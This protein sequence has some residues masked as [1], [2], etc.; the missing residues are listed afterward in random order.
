MKRLRAVLCALIFS[1]IPAYSYAASLGDM[2]IDYLDGD[3]Q[4]KTADTSEWVPASINMPLMDGDAVWV[5]EGGRAGIQLRDGTSVRLAESSSLEILAIGGDSFQFYLSV[6]HAFVNFRGQ[7]GALFQTDTPVS[8]SRA[9]NRARFRIDVSDNGFTDVSVFT[10]VVFTEGRNG[11]TKVTAGNILSIGGDTYAELAPLGPADDWERWNDDMDKK[12]EQRYSTRYL[13]S[14]LSAYSYDFDEY[15]KWVNSADYGYVWIPTAVSAGWSPYRFGR[16]TWIGGDYVWVS[17]DP[18]GWAPYHYGRWA[19]GASTGW[20]WVP[21]ARGAAY[22][23]PGYVAWVNTPTYVS[24][25]PLAPGEIYYG[26]GYYGPHSVNITNININT[27]HVTNVYRNSHVN[28]A[29]T[30]V[31]RD[32]FVS[33]RHVDV[34]VR[35]NP[36]LSQRVSVGRPDIAPTR[37]SYMPVVKSISASKEPPRA[38]R[39]IEVNELRQSRPVVKNPN[40]SVLRPGAPARQM[41]VTTVNRPRL[42][43]AAVQPQGLQPR[44]TGRE[45]QRGGTPPADKGTRGTEVQ[46]GGTPPADKGTR[47]TEVQRGGTPPA[48]KGTRG[49]EVQRGGTPPADKGTRGTEVQR[50]GTPPAD[51]GTRGT[52]VQRGGTPPADKGTRGTEVQR[53]G[54]PPADKGT[55]GTEVQRGGTPPAD[56]GTAGRQGASQQKT[57]DKEKEQPQETGPARVR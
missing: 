53:G 32:T 49:T 47:G 12:L 26:H 31:H 17:Y 35:E 46:R 29:V 44:T 25:V 28:N 27:I 43:G 5:P 14:E 24:W 57:Q 20:C 30:V 45:V 22:W 56:K 52:E 15:G 19:F 13:P 55:R 40:E 21:P 34:N 18:W 9:Y 3:V 11:R 6:G 16:W 38:I 42:P 23:G 2:R 54:T 41:A 37:A 33:G 7:K 4:V 39:Q 10:G 50:G 1:L 51:K 36:F 48:D 8:S